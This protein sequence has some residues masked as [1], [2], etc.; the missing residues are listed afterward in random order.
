M[1]SLPIIAF[2][3]LAFG[4]SAA[5]G[6]SLATE[7]AHRRHFLEAQG[8]DILR[9]RSI[10]EAGAADDRQHYLRLARELHE[11]Y[12]LTSTRGYITY[13]SPIFANLLNIERD[14]S[15]YEFNHHT[16]DTWTTA[17]NPHDIFQNYPACALSPD[18]TEG[19]FY[20]E[21][22]LVRSDLTKGQTGVPLHLKIRVKDI[23]T[24]TDIPNVYVEIW[25]YGTGNLHGQTFG[26]GLQKTDGMGIVSFDT[27]FPGHYFGRAPHIHVAV[28]VN[29][30]EET[31]G[32]VNNNTVSMKA[33]I[34]FDQDLITKIEKR[35]PYNTNTQ[36][37]TYNKDD[38]FLIQEAAAD[39]DPFVY[40]IPVSR[41]WE[42]GLIAWITVGANLTE[43]W[44]MTVADHRD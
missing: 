23:A 10:C 31:D 43:R 17:T 6:G 3:S 18:A 34:Y 14:L 29:A 4:L 30:H 5:H 42:D 37:F 2:I 12:D 11:E 39:F 28:H 38:G 9:A 13:H 44:E 19:P 35:S 24:C 27:I 21:G 20:V 8:W 22:E 33:Q 41:N 25:R 40:W 16:N 36:P 1:H 7:V 15:N 26:R 32:S